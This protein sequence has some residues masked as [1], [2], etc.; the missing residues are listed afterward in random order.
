MKAPTDTRAR[1]HAEL[2]IAIV[3]LWRRATLARCSEDARR[4]LA[5]I[6]QSCELSTYPEA[7][8]YFEHYVAEQ[9]G[10]AA[11]LFWRDLRRTSASSQVLRGAGA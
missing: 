1:R 10:E 11:A 3:D 7:R 2:L 9:L 8:G 4:C 5:L 6:V